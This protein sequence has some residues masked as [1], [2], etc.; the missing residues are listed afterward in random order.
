MSAKSAASSSSSA[1]KDDVITVDDDI[2]SD[3]TK[4]PTKE[5]AC[6]ALQEFLAMYSDD[7]E[8]A[9]ISCP[10]SSPKGN[11]WGLDGSCAWHDACPPSAVGPRGVL[12]G[13]VQ[14]G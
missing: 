2:M 13:G 1:L 3:Q 14:L 9:N 4:D 7:D 6:A 8:E 5:G 11:H 10:N 12:A